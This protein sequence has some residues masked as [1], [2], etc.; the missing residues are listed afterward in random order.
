MID[1]ETYLHDIS[2]IAD[3]LGMIVSNHGLRD[4]KTTELLPQSEQPRAIYSTMYALQVAQ[5]MKARAEKG[6]AE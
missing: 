4:S 3:I 1:E 5:A 6:G 2:I